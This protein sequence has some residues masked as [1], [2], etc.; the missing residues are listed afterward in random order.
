MTDASHFLLL[1]HR[2][3]IFI[4]ALG[5][6][7]CNVYSVNWNVSTINKGKTLARLSLALRGSQDSHSHSL[8]VSSPFLYL[9]HIF[10]TVFPKH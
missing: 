8:A 2:L 4:Y 10:L 6:Q 7:F 1:Y 9:L 5:L 3:F